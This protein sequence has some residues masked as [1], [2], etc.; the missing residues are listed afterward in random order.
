[1]RLSNA[2]VARLTCPAGQDDLRAFDDKMPGFG[3]RVRPS[4]AK[5]WIAQYRVGKSP[6]RTYTIGSAETVDAHEARKRA[7]KIIARAR[8]GFDPRLELE[9]RRRKADDT[10]GRIADMFLDHQKARL[11]PRTLVEV[12]RHLERDWKPLRHLVVHNISRSNIAPRLA[13]IA[14][15]YGT[16][17]ADHARRTLMTLF[18]FGLRQGLIELQANPVAFTVSA[19]VQKARERVLT[20]LELI[21]VW[22]A[23]GDDDYGRII[24]VLLATGQRRDE[25]G[26]I[27]WSELDFER[28][29]WSIPGSRT[30]NSRPHDVYLSDL[31]LEILKRVPRRL[32]RE[33]LFGSGAGALSGWSAAEA[34]LDQR[35]LAILQER[36]G[37]EATLVPWRVH[38]LRRC[39]ATGLQRLGVRLE[40]TEACLNHVSGSRAGIVSVYQRHDFADEK[41]GAFTRWAGH[42]EALVSG[43]TG[44]NIVTLRSAP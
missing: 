18:S 17:A 21:D 25:V 41:R 44:A 16:S 5:V 35:L 19:G 30:K 12:R 39:F 15:E 24:R 6:S 23:A 8:D 42:V 9:D 13:E 3:C 28:R 36:S 7:R 22:N 2:A 10:L 20:D 33:F 43:E 31:V 11:K 37:R 38:D 26:G 1:V 34:K 4:G 32:G 29:I 14:K 27:T 40:V